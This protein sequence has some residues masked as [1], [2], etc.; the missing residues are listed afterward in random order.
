MRSWKEACFIRGLIVA[1][2]VLSPDNKGKAPGLPLSNTGGVL[3]RNM[4]AGWRPAARRR[5]SAAF[6]RQTTTC[7]S[8][9]VWPAFTAVISTVAS[10]GSPCRLRCSP[11][12]RPSWGATFLYLEY[13]RRTS[14]DKALERMPVLTVDGPGV[15]ATGP[16]SVFLLE[17]LKVI[18][19]SST[20]SPDEASG[21]HF[22]WVLE[23]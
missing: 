14:A 10:R 16:F 21:P 22:S 17:G 2:L 5:A 1:V 9:R 3:K 4:V 8:G 15:Q 20:R 19:G 12:I 6:N 11:L 7:L 23:S 13:E 18:S